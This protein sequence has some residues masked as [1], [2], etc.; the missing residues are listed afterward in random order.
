[1]IENFNMFLEPMVLAM[2]FWFLQISQKVAI[3]DEEYSKLMETFFIG[4]DEILQ[5]FFYYNCVHEQL[6]KNVVKNKAEDGWR[7]LMHPF[8][9]DSTHNA[10]LKLINK[11]KTVIITNSYT[12]YAFFY[13]T[14]SDF[15]QKKQT[16]I[17]IY[18]ITYS[19]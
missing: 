16:I 7:L 6:V 4:L 12:R 14:F 19:V 11:S 13:E 10:A 8:N 15:R 9:K 18:C 5:L 1:M 17:S 2:N 3:T